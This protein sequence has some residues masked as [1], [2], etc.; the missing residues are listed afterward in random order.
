VGAVVDVRD[1][2]LIWCQADILD[3]YYRHEEVEAVLVHYH[4]WH[5]TYDEVIYIPSSRIAPLGFFTKRQD[6]SSYTL[7]YT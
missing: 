6:V 2:E 7:K 3:V 5:R 4:H 1:T